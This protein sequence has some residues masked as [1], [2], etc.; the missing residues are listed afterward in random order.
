MRIRVPLI[1]SSIKSNNGIVKVK[2]I[3]L[4]LNIFVIV[5][6]EL[7]DDW[8]AFLELNFHDEL[9]DIHLFDL[10]ILYS[11]CIF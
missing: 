8:A 10:L 11:L 1:K 9:K 7:I 3:F 4:K 2:D 5:V 6:N